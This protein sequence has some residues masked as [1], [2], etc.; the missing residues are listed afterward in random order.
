MTAHVIPTKGDRAFPLIVTAAKRV[1]LFQNTLQLNR[2]LFKE[3]LYETSVETYFMNV[4]ENILIKL[5]PAGLVI[6]NLIEVSSCYV[7]LAFKF[8]PFIQTELITNTINS[9]FWSIFQ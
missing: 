5:L 1:A 3:R 7:A 4:F 2:K 6:G 8:A 9:V